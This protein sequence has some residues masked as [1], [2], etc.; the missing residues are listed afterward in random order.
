MRE[1]EFTKKSL[2]VSSFL[3]DFIKNVFGSYSAVDPFYM[4][5]V[6]SDMVWE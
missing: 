4:N 6:G 5:V 2:P 3:F 1:R